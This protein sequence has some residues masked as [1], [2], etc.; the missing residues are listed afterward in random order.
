MALEQLIYVSTA[1]RK[2]SRVELEALLESA[3]RFN[4][5]HHITGMLLYSDGSFL[6]ILEAETADMDEVYERINRDLQHHSL[7]VLI[8]NPISSRSFAAWHMGF[9]ML[10]QKEIEDNPAFAPF[11]ERGFDASSIGAYEGLALRILQEF[12]SSQLPN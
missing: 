10:G 1:V 12:A 4:N 2:M 5:E 6:Q 7:Q 9:R 3:V 11:F 8:R